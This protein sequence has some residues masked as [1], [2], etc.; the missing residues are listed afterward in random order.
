MIWS[1]YSKLAEMTQTPEAIDRSVV[2]LQEK[3]RLFLKKNETVLI[4]FP[5]MENAASRILERCGKHA[6]GIDGLEAELPS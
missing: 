2:Y 5:K 3:M 6:Y 4:L 1:D